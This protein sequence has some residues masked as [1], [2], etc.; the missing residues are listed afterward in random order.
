MALETNLIRAY[1]FEES[2]G[3]II[4]AT[5]TDNATNTGAT[6][7]VTGKIGK[8]LDFETT[9]KDFVASN[10]NTGINGS[11]SWSMNAWIKAESVFNFSS[12]MSL[13]TQGSVN[14]VIGISIRSG[15]NRLF[16]NTWGGVGSTDIDAGTTLIGNWVMITMTYDGT[17]LKVYVNGNSTPVYSG[18]GTLTL[19]DNKFRIGEVGGYTAGQ[20]FDGLIDMPYLWDTRAISTTEI[21]EL[22]NSGNGLAYPFSTGTNCKINIGDTFKDVSEFKINIGDDWKAVSS[23]KQNIGDSWKTVF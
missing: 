18:T 3:A 20:Y 9:E 21:A 6:Y 2:S 11:E 22:Y 16:I 15:T 8:C 13:G 19:T 5:G 7:G 10:S 12:I 1:N 4:D 23:I 17:N 14:K